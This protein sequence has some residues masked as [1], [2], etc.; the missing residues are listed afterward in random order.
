[1]AAEFDRVAES[2]EQEIDRSIAFTGQEH[3]FFVEAKTR[4]LLDLARRRLGDPGRLRALDVGCGIGLADARLAP[5]LGELH[6][7]DPSEAALE[8]ARRGN[9]AVR[10]VAADGRSLPYED[11]SFD[12][13]F[14][15]CV[16]HHVEP[17]LRANVARELARVTR[18]GGV[19]AIFEHNPL[20]PMTRR[21]VRN[22]SFDE[23][24]V[25]LGRRET[26]GLLA[27]AG[28]RVVEQPYVLFFPWRSPLLD[29]AERALGPVP[30]GAQYL[31]AAERA[32]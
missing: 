16:L 30:L 7:V 11:A 6:G 2:Y 1:V 20:N 32:A 22:C 5:E 3:A 15:I 12:L 17:A 24:V 29:R 31:V 21:V 13:V 9:P 18:P 14:A 4:R 23:G 25:L 10:Y 19:V 28:L 27:G 26:R 8:R